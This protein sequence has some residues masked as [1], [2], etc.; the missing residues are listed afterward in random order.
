MNNINN[1]IESLNDKDLTIINHK[2]NK[3]YE[4]KKQDKI[5]LQIILKEKEKAFLK[6]S[7]LLFSIL[8]RTD[9][10]GIKLKN[11]YC[12]LIAFIYK[13]IIKIKKADNAL[14]SDK[15]F[16]EFELVYIGFLDSLLNEFK[17]NYPFKKELIL[18]DI[19]NS[20]SSNE[21][22]KILKPILI[23]KNIEL[24]EKRKTQ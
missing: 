17:D 10:N 21:V 3:V 12:K 13:D 20:Y 8:N 23:N 18:N 11:K 14:L 16:K 15:E 22:K 1:Y 6:Y 19:I 2:T 4:L 7:N 9:S 24:R 5:K